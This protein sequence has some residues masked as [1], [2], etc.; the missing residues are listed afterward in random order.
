M[1]QLHWIA[2][3]G[4]LLIAPLA[5]AQ[6]NPTNT[7][8]SPPSATLQPLSAFADIADD[9]QRAR[10]LFAEIGK[11]IQHPRCVN[12]HPLSERP[13][14][15]EAGALHQPLVVRGAGGMGAAG[16]MCITCHN[17]ENFRNVPGHPRWHLAPAEMAWEGKSLTEICAQIKDPERNGG[18]TLAELGEHG[19]SCRA[20]PPPTR[21]KVRSRS[22]YRETLPVPVAEGCHTE[23]MSSAT[24]FHPSLPLND[25]PS[26]YSGRG[27]Q[28]SRTLA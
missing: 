3:V 17:A 28:S 1:S 14:Q 20:E 25:Q 26:V 16:M 13:L 8:S 9:T 19:L 11:V 27:R 12:C 24:C 21:P 2:I 18:K 5:M 23:R 7:R 15:G 22:L 6:S 10:A 4:I